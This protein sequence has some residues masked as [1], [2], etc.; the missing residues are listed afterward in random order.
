ML[1][2]RGQTLH[3]NRFMKKHLRQHL[4]EPIQCPLKQP[5]VSQSR[6]TPKINTLL[7]LESG[8]KQLTDIAILV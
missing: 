3:S 6:P 7:T 1:V 4:T 5:V 2:T 8:L